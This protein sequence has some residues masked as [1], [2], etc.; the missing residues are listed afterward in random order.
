MSHHKFLQTSL[1]LTSS[2]AALAYS[3]NTMADVKTAV[4]KASLGAIDHYGV[5]C[6]QDA[7]YIKTRVRDEGSVSTSLINV[8]T[9]KDSMATANNNV[10]ISATDTLGGDQEF[11]PWGTVN[12][13]G[14]LYHVVV[15]NTAAGSEQYTVEA[16]CF[17][18]ADAAT[19]ISSFQLLASA[20]TGT[21]TQT[22]PP[23]AEDPSQPAFKEEIAE[24]ASNIN[25]LY[26]GRGCLNE[27]GNASPVTLQSVV[28]PTQQPQI[29]LDVVTKKATKKKPAVIQP[30]SAADLSEILDVASLAN[31]F[32]LV[33]NKS[34]FAELREKSDTNNNVIG[35]EGINGNAKPDLHGFT[36]FSFSGVNFKADSCVK[37]VLVKVA[38]A[39]VC[40]A[41]FFPPALG[42]ANLWIP[43]V[44]TIFVEPSVGGIG[45]SPTLIINRTTRIPKKDAQGRKCN[46]GW[47][48]SVSPSATDIDANLPMPDHWGAPK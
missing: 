45:Y 32:Q 44:T 27:A 35:F 25:G 3:P 5:S 4:L 7:A 14:G 41:N 40:D 17:T 43:S 6:A 31:K 34:V 39:D 24:G 47:D 42:T 9:A 26:I 37:R 48:V 36:P 13:G 30:E 8:A 21:G 1:F 22:P 2:I 38:V 16:Q 18:A 15:F 20:G 33:Q 23:P 10:A 19:S 46:G 29:T 11:S 12:S 28:F